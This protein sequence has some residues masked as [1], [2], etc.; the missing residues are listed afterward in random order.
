MI[1]SRI[2][3]RVLQFFRTLR[4]MVLP[5]DE[6]Y[7]AARLSSSLL[8]LFRRMPRAD[9]AHCVAVCRALERR[10]WTDDDLLTAALLH[11]VGKSVAPLHLWERVLVVLGEHFIPRR[12]S[13]WAEGEPRG[14]KRCFVTRAKHPA[15]GADLAAEAGATE[16]VVQLIRQHHSPST[17]D[18]M[19]LALQEADG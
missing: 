9:Q 16:R 7:V 1:I 10:G 13:R 12:A 14:W 15:W 6:S 17:D 8:Q 3:Y 18:P 4:D 19:L 2:T 11:D 5:V